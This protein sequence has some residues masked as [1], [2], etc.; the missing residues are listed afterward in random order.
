MHLPFHLL[1]A[2]EL[3]LVGENINMGIFNFDAYSHRTGFMMH[4]NRGLMQ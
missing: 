1:F 4:I 3:L 2:V